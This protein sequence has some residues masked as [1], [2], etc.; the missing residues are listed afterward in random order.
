MSKNKLTEFFEELDDTA[1]AEKK[2]SRKNVSQKHESRKR[3]MEAQL[4]TRA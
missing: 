3:V 4:F 2:S 1:D